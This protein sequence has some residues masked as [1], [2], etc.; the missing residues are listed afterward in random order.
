MTEYGIQ[1]YQELV[2]TSSSPSTLTADFTDNESAVYPISGM[3]SIVVYIQYIPK[4]GQSNRYLYMKVEL[5]PLST[6]LYQVTKRTDVSGKD[7]EVERFIYTTRFKGAIGGTTY[8]PRFA[9]GDIAD[10]FVKLSFK[11]D[12]SDNFGTVFASFLYSGK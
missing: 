12:G 4:T 8:K 5:G 1:H 7:A 10:K 6:D 11:E 3:H 9:I 2:G